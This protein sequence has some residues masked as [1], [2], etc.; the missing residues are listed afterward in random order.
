MASQRMK[1]LSV[2]SVILILELAPA[3]AGAP[4]AAAHQWEWVLTTDQAR[5]V[6]QPDLQSSFAKTSIPLAAE[7]IV[8]DNVV[9]DPKAT[10]QPI[11]GWGGCFNE[12]GWKAM[13]A[14]SAEDRASVLRSLF[15]PQNDGLHLNLCRVPIGASDF[16]LDGYSLD[17]VKDDYELKYFS[18]DR[19]RKLLIPYIKAAMVYRP[20]LR[21]WASPWSPPGWMKD[22]G[23]YHGGT[24]RMEPRVLQ[25]YAQYFVHFVRAYQGEGIHLYAVHVQNEPVSDT[26]YPSCPWKDPKPMADFIRDYLG[27]AFVKDRLNAQIWLGTMSEDRM[28]CFRTILD[29][30]ETAKYI[31]GIGLQYNGRYISE[32][33]HLVYPQIPLIET[34]TPCGAGQNNWQDAERTFGYYRQF[35]EGGVQAYTLWNLVLDETGL[36]TWHWRQ[37]SSIVID[38]KQKTVHY[39]PE[40]YLMKHFSQFVRPGAVRLKLAGTWKDAL[41]FKNADGS[42]VLVLADIGAR[43]E[44]KNVL[45]KMGDEVTSL[46]VP[47]HS[48]ST[49]VCQ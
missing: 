30:P 18:I 36:S 10:D 2:I 16:S 22:N 46:S 25:A 45:I 5:W 12:L 9:I 26:I 28:S 41:S 21:L 13:L 15:D 7:N 32:A 49:L 44:A 47:P 27:P 40:F 38:T 11:V 42:I 29:D 4:P 20:D 14:L 24:L 37:N 19:D 43:A 1:L 33:L 35:L 23:T 17:D 48:F 8:A 6:K 34:E 3:F 39:T 31:S